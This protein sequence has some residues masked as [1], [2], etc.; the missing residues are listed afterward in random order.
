[1]FFIADS[2]GRKAALYV[3]GWIANGSC[4]LKRILNLE[5]SLLA[6]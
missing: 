2:A 6:A 1:M 3:K 5:I 4:L